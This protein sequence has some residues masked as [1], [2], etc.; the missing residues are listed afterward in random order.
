ME[1]FITTPQ[2]AGT[3]IASETTRFAKLIKSRRITAD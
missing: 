3:F 2:E 1:A